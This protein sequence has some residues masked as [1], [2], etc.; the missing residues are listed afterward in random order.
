MIHRY[1]DCAACEPGDE[2]EV[3][4][5]GERPIDCPFCRED[6]GLPPLPEEPT[7]PEPFTPKLFPTPA[8]FGS[9]RRPAPFTKKT[10]EIS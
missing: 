9:Y 4:E 5:H 2:V 3:E 8:S 10:D 7:T 1:E 6:L